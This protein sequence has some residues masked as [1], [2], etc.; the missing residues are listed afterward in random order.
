MEH[1]TVP[2]TALDAWSVQMCSSRARRFARGTVNGVN[3][4][5]RGTAVKK[6]FQL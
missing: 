3:E 2:E 1:L 6:L 4:V 5:Y